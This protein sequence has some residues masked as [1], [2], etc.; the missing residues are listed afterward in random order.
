ML[1]CCAAAVG[2]VAVDVGV[3]VGVDMAVSS[4]LAHLPLGSLD[5]FAVMVVQLLWP[6]HDAVTAA[7]TN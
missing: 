4:S 3:D 1:Y 6:L 7:S 5:H 2:V